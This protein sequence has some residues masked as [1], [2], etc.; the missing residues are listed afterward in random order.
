MST[1]SSLSKLIDNGRSLIPRAEVSGVRRPRHAVARRN[2]NGAEA[3]ESSA[4]AARRS[5][6]LGAKAVEPVGVGP[7]DFWDISADRGLRSLLLIL[8]IAQA[9]QQAYRSR[10]AHAYGRNLIFV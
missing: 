10:Q 7:A 1:L 6:L 9:Y 3:R 8:R 2:A 5:S 4:P